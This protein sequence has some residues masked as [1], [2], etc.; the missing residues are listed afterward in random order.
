VAFLPQAATNWQ[1][2]GGGCDDVVFAMIWYNNMLHVG[3]TFTRCGGQVVNFVAAW[4]GNQ[5]L[6]LNGGLDGEVLA[7]AIYNGDLIVGGR[8]LHAGGVLT[9]SVA[10]WNG[11]SWQ[12][13]TNNCNSPICDPFILV[14]TVSL[15]VSGQQ[16]LASSFFRQGA[17]SLFVSNDDNPECQDTLTCIASDYPFHAQTGSALVSWNP[18]D[19]SWTMLGS[20]MTVSPTDFVGSMAFNKTRLQFCVNNNYLAANNMNYGSYDFSVSNFVDS[21][22]DTNDF[23]FAITSV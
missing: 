20:P 1:D 8:F 19:R 18:N 7:L 2:V 23:V 21:G 5:W 4:N 16:L 13:L 6:S 3:G 17:P 10:S 22:F 9:Y 15:Q 11:K 12:G 14:Q